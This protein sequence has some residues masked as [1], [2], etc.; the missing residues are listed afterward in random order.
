MDMKIILIAALVLI[1]ACTIVEEQEPFCGDSTL[2]FCNEDQDCSRAGCS[3]QV[4]Q[5]NFQD[6]ISTTCEWKE[7]YNHLEYN[8][9]CGGV[10][11]QCQWN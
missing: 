10:N 11:N 8:L 3:L 2:G 1:S 5:S 7:C 4:C 6:P 9:E